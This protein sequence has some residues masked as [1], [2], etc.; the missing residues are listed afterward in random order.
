LTSI[1]FAGLLPALQA[2]RYD[3]AMSGISDTPVREKQVNF[4]DYFNAG[5]EFIVPTGN[6]GHISTLSDLCG[7]PVAV[8]QGTISV[9]IVQK[10]SVQ[11]T[12]SGKSAVN[13][14][15]FPS[16]SEAVLAVEDGRAD[17]NIA[18]YTKADYEATHSGGKLA[19]AGS[20]FDPT[21]TGIAIAKGN[22]ALLHAIQGA[23][24]VII[25]NGTYGKIL[26][27]WHVSDGAVTSA[28]INAATA[29]S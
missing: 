9:T 2:G 21:P 10:Q 4:V 18:D 25:K 19:V 20:Q 28:V 26:A 15:S 3:I 24:N 7:K 16:A 5:E 17:A 6:P 1:L 27:K 29:A 11:C 12:S 14:L 13:A 23:L 22:T 8:A